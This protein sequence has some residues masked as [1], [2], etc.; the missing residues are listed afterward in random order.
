[1]PIERCVFKAREAGRLRVLYPLLRNFVQIFHKTEF[2]KII[3]AASIISWT[4][5]TV[6]L[7]KIV[8]S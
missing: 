8:T 2:M 3:R 4:I 6:P 5:P 7:D 1:M